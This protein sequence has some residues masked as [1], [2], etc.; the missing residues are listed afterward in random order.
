MAKK[1]ANPERP[2]VHLAGAARLIVDGLD[3]VMFLFCQSQTV[4]NLLNENALSADQQKRL[5]QLLQAA[6][7]RARRVVMPAE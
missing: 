6:V 1:Q 4:A 3:D 2:A 7:D 5:G